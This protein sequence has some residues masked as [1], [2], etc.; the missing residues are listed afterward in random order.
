MNLVE[1]FLNKS[2]PEVGRNRG[3]LMQS[4]KMAKG[5]LSFYGTRLVISGVLGLFFAFHAAKHEDLG[6]EW[7]Q[8][9]FADCQ[10]RI[11]PSKATLFLRKGKGFNHRGHGGKFQ[12]L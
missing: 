11:E 9:S 4:G 5:S 6:V 7:E 1:C 12:R 8:L 3:R 10:Q 2:T